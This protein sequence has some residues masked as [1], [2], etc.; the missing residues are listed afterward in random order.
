LW[1][2]Y[3]I[4]QTVEKDGRATFS[5]VQKLFFGEINVKAK[6]CQGKGQD[7][8]DDTGFPGEKLHRAVNAQAQQCDAGKE[9]KPPLIHGGY[10]PHSMERI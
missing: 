7:D 8:M 6:G 3:K 5:T 1:A 9:N 4:K 2:N 10:L